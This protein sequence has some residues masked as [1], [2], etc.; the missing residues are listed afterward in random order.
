VPS[1][2]ATRFRPSKCVKRTQYGVV[3]E[4]HDAVLRRWS[5][6]GARAE[7]ERRINSV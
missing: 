6:V 4:G 3:T 1:T 5:D 2:G 7:S